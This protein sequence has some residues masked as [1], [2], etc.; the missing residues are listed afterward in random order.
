MEEIRFRAINYKGKR[1][2]VFDPN[3]K[4]SHKNGKFVIT[5][6]KKVLK[7]ETIKA[8]IRKLLK[9]NP[10]ITSKVKGIKNIEKK[11]YYIKVWIITES[12]DLTVMKNHNK[13]GFRRYHLDH[14]FPIS[15]GFKENIPPKAIGDIRN[16]QFLHFRKNLKK[17]DSVSERAKNIINEIISK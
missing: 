6:K 1:L 10:K 4:Y 13:R 11:L 12:N 14:I 7:D 2:Y 3:G 5:T 16:L 15:Q 17:R 8:T 9:S